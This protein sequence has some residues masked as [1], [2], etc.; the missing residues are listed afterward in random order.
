MSEAGALLRAVLGEYIE[1]DQQALA[2]L[3][4]ALELEVDPLDYC[5]HRFD[6]G[7]TTVMERAAA[8]AGL[9]FF[10]AVPATT[11]GRRRID[12][13]E[14][15]GEARSIQVPLLDREI[16]YSAP[17]FEKLLHLKLLHEIRPDLRRMIAIVPLSAIRAELAALAEEPMMDAAKHRLMRHWPRA[18]GQADAPRSARI[19]FVVALAVLLAGVTLAPW[20]NATLF[21][22]LVGMVLLVP[23]LLR[24][25][26]AVSR[27]P[28]TP[29]VSLLPDSD[30]P[31]YTI[32]VPLRD[33]ADMVG[34][35]A[36][37]L[38]RIDYPPEKL[39]VLFVV[40][41]RSLSTVAAVQQQLVDPRF[42]LVLVPDALPRTKPK[43]LNYALP[44]V[45]G[46]HVVVAD[47]ED[48]PA[49]RQLRLAASTFAA[50]PE[51]MCLQAELVIDNASESPLAALF[52]GEYAGQ[53]GLMLPLLSRLD[54][55]MPLGGTSNHFRTDA[56]RR[57]GGWDAF[58]VTEDA[59]LG[60]R[61]ARLKLRTATIASHTG[62]EAPIHIGGWLRQRS[63]W[64]KGWMQTLIVHDRHWRSLLR[65][66]GWPGFIGFHIYVGSMIFSAPLHSAFL[67]SFLASMVTLN[68]PGSFDW[69]AMLTVGVFI[70]GYLGPI[71]LVVAGLDR[72]QRLDL[73]WAQ[74]L[75]PAYWLL[76]GAA[77]AMA[78]WE[79][80]VSPFA[81]SKTKHGQ[82]RVQR[83]AVQVVEAQA[84]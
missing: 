57:V 29:M 5:A 30:L 55:P 32:L 50:H 82:T 11:S 78:A 42:E 4:T 73:L 51:L 7:E 34:Q 16:V 76:H 17:H 22:P 56:L 75:L 47:A 67:L 44:L 6:L 39:D 68:L 77:L 2:L 53:F 69:G 81:W 54:L 3:E 60:V 33:E 19:G 72:L 14:R 66:L 8:W 46:E 58:N 79:L 40:E 25:A 18:A 27:P 26:A 80:V 23:A 36:E 1:S 13:I 20:I 64:M 10:P 52:A 43:A 24:L 35:L 62:E 37:A 49:P 12:R 48:I 9:E 21:L 70:L 83:L 71:L 31:I 61:L 28:P 65:D 84:E 45:R 41:K 74:L 15:L 38:K 59:D 63:R